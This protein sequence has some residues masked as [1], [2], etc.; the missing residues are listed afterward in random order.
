MSRDRDG[1][2]RWDSGQALARDLLLDMA[3]RALSG[4][5]PEPDPVLVQAIATVLAGADEDRAFAAQMLAPPLET[6]IAQTMNPADPEAIHAARTALVREVAR[7]NAEMFQNLY[8]SLEHSGPFRP[9][10]E[11]AG[12]RALRNACLRYLTAAD[13]EDAARMADHHYRAAANMTDMIAGLAQ[14]SRMDGRM[15]EEAFAHFHDRFRDDALVLDKWF[16]LQAMS[17]LPQTVHRVRELMGHP[18]FDLRNPNRVRALVG[19]FSANHLRFHSGDGQGYALVGET[20]R[21]LDAINPQVAARMAGAFENWRRYDSGRQ[22]LM[23]RELEAMLA[24][25]NCSSNT[26]EVASK[27][28]G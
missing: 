14:L 23:R 25:P 5:A 17:P 8:A 11:A 4:P 26:F 6:E 10:A 16:A 27:M 21:Q 2:N 15:R 12:R 9:D 28:L 1:F 24:I 7:S 13:D 3:R 19:A 18:C 20:L 22:A